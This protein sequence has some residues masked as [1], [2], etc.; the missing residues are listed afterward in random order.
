MTFGGGLEPS[1][2]LAYPVLKRLG[3]DVLSA[4]ESVRQLQITQFS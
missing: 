3:E 4:H 1:Q 2:G